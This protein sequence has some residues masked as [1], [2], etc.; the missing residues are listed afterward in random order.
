MK[1]RC[2]Y[3]I[4][5]SA[6]SGGKYPPFDIVLYA[7]CTSL[8]KV[9]CTS[10]QFVARDAPLPSRS[11]VLENCYPYW[12]LLIYLIILDR[13]FYSSWVLFP[14]L[15]T[16]FIRLI[17]TLAFVLV[18]HEEIRCWSGTGVQGLTGGKEGI[19]FQKYGD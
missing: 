6:F 3:S 2:R 1:N 15:V 8:V 9:L 19:C 5:H 13:V 7:T 18:F 17:R 10:I 4:R 11:L 14:V 12:A 16:F